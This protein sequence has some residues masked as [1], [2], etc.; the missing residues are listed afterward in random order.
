MP[1]VRLILRHVGGT[2]ELFSP[3]ILRG[4][5]TAASGRLPPVM[6]LVKSTRRRVVCL[7]ASLPLR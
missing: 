7:E 6:R 3:R 1:S 4:F 5:W 2:L